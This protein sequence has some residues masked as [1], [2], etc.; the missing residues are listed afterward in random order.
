MDERN[1]TPETDEQGGAGAPSWMLTYGDSVTL[2][3]TFFVMLLTFST[4]NE[5]DFGVLARGIMQ[6]ARQPAIFPGSP[7]RDGLVEEERRL[8]QSRLDTEG[9]EK[10]PMAEESPIEDLRKHYEDI[11]VSELPDLKGALVIRLPAA[12]LLDASGGLSESGTKVLNQVVQLARGQPYSLVVRASA[13]NDRA[14]VPAQ[15][16]SAELAILITEYLLRQAPRACEDIGLSDN[17]QLTGEAL[18][19]GMCEITLLEV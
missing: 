4:P 17:I 2:L 7:G 15:R 13:G 19:P 9:A 1:T 6:G 16:S 12:E 18:P 5:E 10:P 11:A 3:L 14:A 8:R